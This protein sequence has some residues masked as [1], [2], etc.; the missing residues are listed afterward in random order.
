MEAGL[1]FAYDGGMRIDKTM[2]VQEHLAKADKCLESGDFNKAVAYYTAIIRLYPL[3]ID[4]WINRGISWM[5]KGNPSQAMAD[6]SQA[7]C[8]DIDCAQAWYHRS[9]VWAEMNKNSKALGDL[10]QAICL[11]PDYAAALA[12]RDSIEQ[13]KSKLSDAIPAGYTLT[14]PM[15]MEDFDALIDRGLYLTKEGDFAPAKSDLSQ[16][17]HLKPD[18]SHAWCYRGMMWIEKGDM[19]RAA[20]DLNESLRI[21]PTNED[22]LQARAKALSSKATE[23]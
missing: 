10:R 22:A 4:A 8:L 16:A 18:R 23:E 21:E 2:T 5:K 3:A 14:D 1:V 9:R 6:L 17:I 13:S 11:Q 12:D 15:D 7:I 20:S 19:E